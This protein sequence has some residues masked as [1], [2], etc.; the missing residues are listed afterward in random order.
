MWLLST[1]I[2]F[3]WLVLSCAVCV[4]VIWCWSERSWSFRSP[5]AGI[6]LCQ[7][8]Y[9]ERLL[10]GLVVRACSCV[11]KRLTLPRAER[12]DWVLRLEK[13]TTHQFNFNWNVFIALLFF[14]LKN[15]KQRFVLIT[16]LALD[17]HQNLED[18]LS[19]AAAWFNLHRNEQ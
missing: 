11:I 17:A 18:L 14:F 8:A 2:N 7:A 16:V 12:R 13:S 1:V 15:S 4:C 3:Q 19:V 9:V 5:A 10:A 6:V